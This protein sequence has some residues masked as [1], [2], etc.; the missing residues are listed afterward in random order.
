MSPGVTHPGF[1]SR[2]VKPE[3][4]GGVPAWSPLCPPPGSRKNADIDSA[5]TGVMCLEDWVDE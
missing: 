2:P 3:C 4:Q 1:G 5:D